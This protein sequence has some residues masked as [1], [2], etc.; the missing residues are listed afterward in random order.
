MSG[1]VKEPQKSRTYLILIAVSFAYIGIYYLLMRETQVCKPAEDVLIRDQWFHGFWDQYLACRSINEL[2]DALAGAFAPVAFIWLAGTV[3]IQSQELQAQRQELD[4]TQGVMRE[5][6]EVA[7]Q[8]VLETKASTALFEEQTRMLRRQQELKEMCVQDE[9]FV[10]LA[11]GFANFLSDNAG[12]FMSIRSI[13]AVPK[14]QPVFVAPSILPTALAATGYHWHV[15]YSRHTFIPEG[16][17]DGELAE[18]TRIIRAS[19]NGFLLAPGNTQVT[20]LPDEAGWHAGQKIFGEVV[21]KL[22]ELMVKSESGTPA[23]KSL[24]QS[25]NIPAT[26]IQ[27]ESMLSW[28][29]EAEIKRR[30]FYSET[31]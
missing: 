27:I 13:S 22:R 24:V 12:L 17:G 4:E 7:R 2:G 11:K 5:Q 18:L 28:V 21:S 30:H 20:R 8:Q 14:S 3:F 31:S 15:G 25:A 1:K 6:L 26:I 16:F 29:Q 19:I 9:E 10:A 23:L